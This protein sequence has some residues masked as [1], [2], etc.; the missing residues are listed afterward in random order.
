[1]AKTL[2]PKQVRFVDEYLVDL[3]ATA[4]AKRSGYSQRTAY[5]IGHALL[6]KE[7]VIAAIVKAERKRAERTELS[8]DWIVEQLVANVNRSMQAEPVLD[9]EGNPTGEYRYEGTVANR[10]LELLGKHRGMFTQTVRFDGDKVEIKLSFDP[11]P[12]DG[13]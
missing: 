2:T 12:P 6:S 10:A 7:H 13:D 8:Q 11:T 5:Q 9:H 3:N 4:A 1:M